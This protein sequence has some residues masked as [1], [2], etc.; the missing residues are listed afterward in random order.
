MPTRFSIDVQPQRDTVKVSPAGE[1]DLATIEELQN[2]LEK[3]IEAGFPRIVVD[4]RRVEFLDSTGLHALLSANAR[5]N[6]EGWQLGIIPGRPGVQRIFE[7]TGAIDQL[8]FTA[9]DGAAGRSEP[10]EPV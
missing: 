3:L 8:P 9:V 4:L 10:N 2:E 1:L 6:E 5:A 7:I